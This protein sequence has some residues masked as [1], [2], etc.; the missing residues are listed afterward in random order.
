M[1]GIMYW[2]KTNGIDIYIAVFFVKM[3]IEEMV[4]TKFNP[5]GPVAM[6]EIAESGILPLMAIQRVTQEI[7][8]YFWR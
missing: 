3:V 7:E 8:V 2:Y 6:Y 5:G 4:N 1:A